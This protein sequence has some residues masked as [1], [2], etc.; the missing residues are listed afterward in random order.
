MI[1]ILTEP[2][3]ELKD[4]EIELFQMSTEYVQNGDTVVKDT[5]NGLKVQTENNGISNYLII[6]TK[7]WAIDIDNINKITDILKDFLNRF[8]GVEYIRQNKSDKA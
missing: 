1:K 5:C 2:D 8:Y 7:R 3:K 6:S 4:D